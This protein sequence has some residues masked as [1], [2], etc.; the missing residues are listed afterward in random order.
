MG[1]IHLDRFKGSVHS[2]RKVTCGV[3]KLHVHGNGVYS[4][5]VWQNV[6]QCKANEIE[7]VR[8]PLKEIICDPFVE[9]LK[10]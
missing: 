3:F 1:E 7:R 10:V 6:K 2:L 5:L 8:L 9:G 4:S